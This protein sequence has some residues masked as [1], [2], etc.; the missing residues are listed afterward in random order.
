MTRSAPLL[1]ALLL[2]LPASSRADDPPADPPSG[3]SAHLEKLGQTTVHFDFAR[4]P[5]PDVTRAL[6]RATGI[7]VKI[8]EKGE[9]A[10]AKRKFKLK[11]VASRTGIQVLEDL[12]KAAALDWE[13]TDEGAILD[14]PAALKKLRK[15]LGLP[16]RSTRLTPADVERLLDQ[17][18]IDLTARDRTLAQVL[19]FLR[20]ETGIGFVHLA[21]E[22]APLARVSL[23]TGELP[24]RQVLDQLVKKLGLHWAR[25]G[26]VVVI[27]SEAAVRPPPSEEPAPE[28]PPEEAP[29]E[30]PEEAPEEPAEEPQGD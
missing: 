26:N 1:L 16:A 6:E 7:P 21:E 2:T 27:G 30:P 20:L 9:Q 12:A 19:D 25:Q 14:V 15:E 4:A 28:Q 5:L 13:V 29:E 8:G 11:Y 10:L 23:A 3:R 17:K 18:K 22:D 24:L